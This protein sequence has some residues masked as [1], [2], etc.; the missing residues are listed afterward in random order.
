MEQKTQAQPPLFSLAQ[1]TLI[2][3]GFERPIILNYVREDNLIPDQS[4]VKQDLRVEVNTSDL[5][6]KTFGVF[7]NTNYKLIIEEQVV[8]DAKVVQCGTFNKLRE[9]TVTELN[10]FANIN[11][12]A[13]I[14]PY[15]REIISSLSSK[16]M[17][18]ALFIQPVNF[19][20]LYEDRKNQ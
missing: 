12:P 15:V 14:F 3:A 11:A 10:D 16:A 6:L 1:I 20:Q 7:L 2:S 18:G 19:I 9:P 13:I 4:T 8:F 5:N 17:L